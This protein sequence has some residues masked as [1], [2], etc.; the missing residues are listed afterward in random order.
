MAQIDTTLNVTVK[1]GRKEEFKKLG[2]DRAKQSRIAN[3]VL[4]DTSFS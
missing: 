2:E 3:Q 4:R 1:E